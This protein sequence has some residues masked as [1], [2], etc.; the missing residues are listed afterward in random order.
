[1]L[2]KS[3]ER[4]EPAPRSRFKHSKILQTR[5]YTSLKLLSK[6]QRHKILETSKDCEK[7][8]KILKTKKIK[9]PKL[10]ILFQNQGKIT[11]TS[12]I[13]TINS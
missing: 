12:R 2:K 13:G 7:P 9:H 1:M 6:L 11:T 8:Q 3:Q 5:R 10:Q 4:L